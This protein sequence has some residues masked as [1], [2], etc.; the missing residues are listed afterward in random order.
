MNI[1]VVSD[2]H[3]SDASH[4]MAFLHDLL[5]GPLRGIDM[6][7]HAGDLVNYDILAGVSQ[8][9][10]YAVR[11]NMDAGHRNLPQR[12]IIKA[13]DKQIA[14]IHGWGPPGGLEQ[15][16]INEFSTETIDALV[17]GHS[18][19]PFCHRH[20][21]VLLFNPGSAAD[22]REA[23]HHTVGLLEVGETIEGR[24]INLD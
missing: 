6:L 16:L 17:F 9:P 24:I 2:T 20:E 5:E 12:R 19:R 1:G 7:L 15:R 10:V 11:G 22:R 3:F 18:H 8:C 21:G 23:D 13:H 14:L 4:G